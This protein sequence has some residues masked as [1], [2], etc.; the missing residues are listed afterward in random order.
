MAENFYALL[1]GVDTYEHATDKFPNLPAAKNDVEA[2]SKTLHDDFTYDC[3]LLLSP[4]KDSIIKAFE[5]LQSKIEKTKKEENTV[6]VY[7]SGHGAYHP[8][9]KSCAYLCAY[10]T[11]LGNLPETAVSPEQLQKFVQAL[12]EHAA[13]VL[14]VLDACHSAGLI[15]KA[16]DDS[17]LGWSSGVTEDYLNYLASGSMVMTSC[18]EDQKSYILETNADPRSFFTEHLIGGLRKEV[19]DNGYVW[20][21]RLFSYVSRQLLRDKHTKDKQ[22]PSH[23]G[24][25]EFH[26]AR[27]RQKIDEVEVHEFF[28]LPP[29]MITYCILKIPNPD[30]NN[31][32]GEAFII[33]TCDFNHGKNGRVYHNIQEMVKFLA[34]YGYNIHY[35]SS[36]DTIYI[37]GA[38]GN[39]VNTT[40]LI[41]MYVLSDGYSKTGILV[42]NQNIGLSNIFKEKELTVCV[43]TPTRANSSTI[44]KLAEALR[45]TYPQALVRFVKDEQLSPESSEGEQDCGEFVKNLL[46]EL[47]MKLLEG[48]SRD[49]KL[50]LSAQKIEKTIT[51]DFTILS[52]SIHNA[53]RDL[54]TALPEEAKDIL[55]LFPGSRPYSDPILNRWYWLTQ[56]LPSLSEDLQSEIPDLLQDFE[57]HYKTTAWQKYYDTL[58]EKVKNWNQQSD[59]HTTRSAK[60][61]FM[62][63]LELSKLL[64]EIEQIPEQSAIDVS[65]IGQLVQSLLQA[66]EKV[67]SIAQR[68]LRIKHFLAEQELNTRIQKIVRIA[69]QQALTEEIYSN[70]LELLRKR[71]A[72]VSNDDQKF[73]KVRR[74]LA[75]REQELNEA[76]NKISKLESDLQQIR[77]APEQVIQDLKHKLD[78]SHKKRQRSVDRLRLKY[79]TNRKLVKDNQGWK[80]EVKQQLERIKH[81]DAQII[82]LNQQITDLRKQHETDQAVIA[83]LQQER[84]KLTQQIT[85]LRKQHTT[86][87]A[88]FQQERD[89]LTQQITGL[90]QQLQQERVALN[91]QITDLR[92]Q[93]TTE[94]AQFQ[95]ERDKLTQ[96]ITGLEQ[97]LQ[98]ERVALNQQITDLREQHT[99]DQAEIAHLEQERDTNQDVI[100][101]L[102]KQKQAQDILLWIACAIVLIFIV[103]LIQYNT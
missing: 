35:V 8:E 83:Q 37:Q 87:L 42:G 16:S 54:C 69:K 103:V 17:H 78:I 81:L 4:N 102:R 74:V 41:F 44:A 52:A 76:N 26:I 19:D 40:K 32:I 70:L 75:A 71:N 90:E 6:L 7:F 64:K 68:N 11:N 31:V 22:T 88:Q 82:M 28:K 5:G 92:E 39:V 57:D 53:I 3:D 99:T 30:T 18:K 84:D 15:T 94:L 79:Q 73:I 96:Q 85:D 49:N 62:L 23:K 29:D 34:L 10:N 89:K 50:S 38:I 2:L 72:G 13:R 65:Q 67:Q 9:N 93:H 21:N 63:Q 95:Q 91:Q 20:A 56:I 48:A 59:N 27:K 51:P 55:K 25:T 12:T 101:N 58:S 14:I 100:A 98:Q 36:N 60:E 47:R 61:K 43:D 86:E 24:S 46:S 33:N 77:T 97:Q 80:L 1:I 66:L 45:N